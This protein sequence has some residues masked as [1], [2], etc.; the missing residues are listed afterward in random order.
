MLL[1]IN[2]IEVFSTFLDCISRNVPSCK[3]IINSNITKVFA[4]NDNKTIRLLTNTNSLTCE[5]E[6]SFCFGELIKLKQSINL[7]KNINKVNNCVIDFNNT[8]I[9]YNNNVKFKLKV[10]KEDIISR[11]I[12]QD[13][14]TKLQYNYKFNTTSG[15]IKNILNSINIINN[16][17]SKIYFSCNDNLVIAEIDDKTNNICDSLG[18]PIGK[19]IEGSVNKVVCIP[20]ESFKSFNTL[21]SDD[22]NIGLVNDIS[23][24]VNSRYNEGDTF[25]ELSI[26]CSIL[27]G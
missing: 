5:Q 9:S 8:F 27:K 21:V 7:I 1:N 20:I 14:K 18:I 25:I 16:S 23:M 24:I 26:L 19:L 6:V 22:I 15:Y 2:N 4:I 13:L 12:S 11:Y 3:F 10:I 17:D